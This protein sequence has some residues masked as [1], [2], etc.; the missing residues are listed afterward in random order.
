MELLDQAIDQHRQL[1]GALELVS[2]SE[3]SS[4]AFTAALNR[5]RELLEAN[6]QI[7][8]RLAGSLA[9][10]LLDERV[11]AR[12]I[13][14]CGLFQSI[15]ACLACYAELEDQVRVRAN[16]AQIRILLEPLLH[17]EE[18]TLRG[19]CKSRSSYLQAA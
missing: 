19:Y 5:A 16:V 1:L 9:S 14:P 3:I 8:E 6:L 17:E 7:R 13:G 15:S 12:Q 4:G 18:R 2:G 10:G 11:D